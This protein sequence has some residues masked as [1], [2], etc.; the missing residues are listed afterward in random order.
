MSK[1]QDSN[2]GALAYI[3]GW[4]VLKKSLAMALVVG[5]VLCIAN[6]LD[7]ILREPMNGRIAVKILFNFL[8]PFVVASVS[9]GSNRRACLRCTRKPGEP[10]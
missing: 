2:P 9:A 3:F 6:Q 1:T 7:V 10:I 8:V 5:C 4:S